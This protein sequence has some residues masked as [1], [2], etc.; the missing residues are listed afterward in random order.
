LASV[1]TDAHYQQF[2]KALNDTRSKVNVAMKNKLH[3]YETQATQIDRQE[4]TPLLN[5]AG[6]E[7]SDI[8]IKAYQALTAELITKSTDLSPLYFAHNPE[9]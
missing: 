3:E 2:I 5:Q 7:I 1:L 9:L 4:L 6:T 8:A